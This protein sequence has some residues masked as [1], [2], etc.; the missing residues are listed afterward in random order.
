MWF[1]IWSKIFIF[2]HSIFIYK[3][4][5]I[6]CSFLVGHW[7]ITRTWN[8]GWHLSRRATLPHHL[9]QCLCFIIVVYQIFCSFSLYCPTWWNKIITLFLSKI[10]LL[11]IILILLYIFLKSLIFIIIFR[12]WFFTEISS[13]GWES[14]SLLLKLI[15]FVL[16]YKWWF[17]INVLLVI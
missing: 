14:A 12:I 4:C 1:N 10:W 13:C 9:H 16:S 7:I 15:I 11:Y 3:F 2:F 8:R 6:F 17:F 5:I